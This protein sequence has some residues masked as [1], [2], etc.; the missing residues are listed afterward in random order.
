MA[1][2]LSEVLKDY[3]LTLV[4]FN[5]IFGDTDTVARAAVISRISKNY[6]SKS[7]MTSDFG[8]FN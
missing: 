8:T 1:V 6:V 2:I 7:R 3:C 5:E 4:E